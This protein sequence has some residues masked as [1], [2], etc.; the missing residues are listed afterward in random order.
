MIIICC[1][2]F[3][4]VVFQ[5]VFFGIST[6][7]WL[8]REPIFTLPYLL[9]PSSST[10]EH[11]QDK[12]NAPKCPTPRGIESLPPSKKRQFPVPA[13]NSNP[14]FVG[15]IGSRL[16]RTTQTVWHPQN[17]AESG[18]RLM[19]IVWLHQTI[20]HIKEVKVG[21]KTSYKRVEIMPLS[22]RE[23]KNSGS[24]PFIVTPFIGAPF[25]SIYNYLEP[26]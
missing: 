18:K 12:K 8:S 1:P 3:F 9:R 10:S 20:P 11:T 25:H 16:F 21:P 26:K 14:E 7:W 19:I 4:I 22:V 17:S 24:I 6:F 15:I 23:K 5:R 13:P 2:P